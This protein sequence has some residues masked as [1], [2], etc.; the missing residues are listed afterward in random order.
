MQGVR[1]V[2]LPQTAPANVQLKLQQ[3]QWTNSKLKHKP[4][5]VRQQVVGAKGRGAAL[6]AQNMLAH[7]SNQPVSTSRLAP[8]KQ[9]RIS[10]AGVLMEAVPH[11]QGGEPHAL[12]II[13]GQLKC[14]Y[15][16]A[17]SYEHSVDFGC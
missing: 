10:K 14:V 7:L 12:A 9:A 13:A 6:L 16:A 2:A 3:L 8:T 1:H 15:T 11:C 5:R 4:L 17:L